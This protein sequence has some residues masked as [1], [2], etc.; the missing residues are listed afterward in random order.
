M[1]CFVLGSGSWGTAL[2][3]HLSGKGCDVV[4]W[5]RRPERAREIEQGRHS[6][7]EGV[8]LTNPIRTKVAG[9]PTETG[10]ALALS[11]IPTQHLRPVLEAH[12][13]EFPLGVPWI[14]ASK[15]LELRRGRLPSQILTECGVV[16]EVAIL[17]G[18]SHAEEV[19]RNVPTAVVLGC[20]DRELGASLQE[21]LSSPTLRIYLNQD[22]LGVEWGGALKNVIAV[23]AGIAIGYGFGD[24]T[25]AAL[26]TRG[27]V[28]MARLGVA[29][30]G[31]RETFSGLSGIGDL[32]VTCF[33]RHSR[34]RAF[35][36]RIGQGEDPQE[37]LASSPHV[38]EGAHT[39]KAVV[40]LCRS[41]DVEMPIAEE[42]HLIVHQGKDVG[43]GVRALLNRSLKEE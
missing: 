39:S 26:V 18:P 31:R 28:E 38:V 11:A 30:G 16:P 23:A 40:E 17:S 35:G 15:G 20:G 21:A 7:L 24:N 32:M 25:L 36:I 33:S 13:T 19:I 10:Y 8:T 5:C 42:V 34:N 14:S 43:D 12:R 9:D 37:V 29:L 22:V 3:G 1:K 6:L 2:A 27:A 4:Q 41:L